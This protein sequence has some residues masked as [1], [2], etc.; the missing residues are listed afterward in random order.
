M[1]DIKA[2]N[3]SA[4][5]NYLCRPTRANNQ[6]WKDLNIKYSVSTEKLR[7]Y[8]G[9]IIPGKS[10]DALKREETKFSMKVSRKSAALS[11]AASVQ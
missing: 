8:G 5:S 7:T 3:I 6:N 9:R 2:E 4:Q 1:A 10:N 11:P